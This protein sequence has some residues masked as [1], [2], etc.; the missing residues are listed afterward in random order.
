MT[1][2]ILVAGAV[3]ASLL[4]GTAYA[5]SPASDFGYASAALEKVCTL[6]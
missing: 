1:K 3:L 2:Y 4:S 6:A 5:D